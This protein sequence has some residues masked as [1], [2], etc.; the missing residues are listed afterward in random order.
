MP[1]NLNIKEA[2]LASQRC[3]AAAHGKHADERGYLDS[4][5]LNLASP[6]SATSLAAFSSGDGGEMKGRPGRPAKMSALHSSSALA[7][8]VFDHWTNR[9]RS[10]LQRALGLPSVIVRVDFECKC[11]TGLSGNPPNLDVALP[12]RDGTVL[13]IESKFTEWMTAKRPRLPDFAT[14]YLSRERRLWEVRGLVRCQRLAEAVADGSEQFRHLDVLQLLKHALGLATCYPGRF[15][16][17]YCY[18][19]QSGPKQELH[20]AEVQRFDDFV[21]PEIQFRPLD[22]KTLIERLAD[23]CGAQPEHL[24]YVTYLQ[25]RYGSGST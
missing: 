15:S 8:N 22:Y 2:V 5:E 6:M 9:D 17:G 18:A 19:Y 7:V 13:A 23:A 3:W 20:A 11:A 12:L 1:S 10:P 21:G 14:K 25:A 24:A 16:L 4:Y